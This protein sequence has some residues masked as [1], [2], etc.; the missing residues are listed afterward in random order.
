M[1]TTRPAPRGAEGLSDSQ[2][3]PFWLLVGDPS[4]RDGGRL[5][6]FGTQKMGCDREVCCRLTSGL[7]IGR[8]KR[9]ST[10]SRSVC[11]ITAWALEWLA[12]PDN[13]RSTA[14]T[15]PLAQP[16]HHR[17]TSAAI[18]SARSGTAFAAFCTTEC[19]LRDR[20]SSGYSLQQT[21]PRV[22][23]SSGWTGQRSSCS[24]SARGQTSTY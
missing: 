12:R 17:P 21:S 15:A 6:A 10:L 18:C 9:P 24:T 3:L 19:P 7:E 16:L 1:D 4:G 2:N 8:S 13:Q 5:G 11:V 22:S 20:R 14:L 23:I